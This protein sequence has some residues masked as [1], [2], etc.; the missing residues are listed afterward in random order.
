[1]RT[2]TPPMILVA[3]LAMACGGK[4]ASTTETTTEST[5]DSSDPPSE[6]APA[7]M[8]FKDMTREQRMDYMKNTVLPTMKMTFQEFDAKR[9]GEMDCKTCHGSGATDGTFKM[10][11]PDLPRLPPPEKFMDFAKEPEHA[12]WVE[13]MAKKV[14]PQMATLLKMSEFDPATNTGDF[15]CHNCHLT[16]GE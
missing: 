12:P 1:M 10:P 7:D 14:K 2:I 13:F 11:S 15:S 3:T 9:F 6:A 8:A 4:P 16:V 5:T